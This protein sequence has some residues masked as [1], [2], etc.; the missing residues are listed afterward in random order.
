MKNHSIIP[1]AIGFVYW[2]KM[3]DRETEKLK[4]VKP[5]ARIAKGKISTV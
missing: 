1:R 2:L 3:R 5:F 4:I